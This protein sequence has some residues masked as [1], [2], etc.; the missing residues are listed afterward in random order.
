MGENPATLASSNDPDK[1]E[2]GERT[3][4]ANLEFLEILTV[5]SVVEK[6]LLDSE[7]QAVFL[8]GVQTG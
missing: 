3:D 4:R 7:A 1:L 5:G 2:A 6:R 8:K